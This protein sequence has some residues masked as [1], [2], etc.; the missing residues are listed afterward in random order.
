V[1]AIEVRN[2]ATNEHVGSVPAATDGDVADVAA[3]ARSAQSRWSALSFSERARVISRFHDLVL[4]RCSRIL[5]VIQSETGKARRD[6]FAEVLT[7]AGTARYY[8]AHGARHLHTRKKQGA[9]PFLTRAEVA[10]HPLGVVGL[11]EPWNYPFL[12]PAGDA[13]PALLAGNAVVIK[14]SELTPLSSDLTRELLIESGLDPDLLGVVHGA[15]ATGTQMIRHV[16]YVGFTG[17]TATG[18]KVA[19]AAA[20]RL[21]PFSLELGGKNPMVVL[22]GAPLKAAAKAFLAGTF[23]N[24]GQTC[25]AIERA[26]IESSV[27]D[28]FSRLVVEGASRLKVGWSR[29]WDMDVGSLIHPGHAGKVMA[30]IED[31]VHQGATLL[32]GGRRR[33]DLGPSFV[34][35][36]IFTNVQDTMTI[37]GEETF[38]PVVSLYPV[39]GVEDAVARANDSKY[40]LNASVWSR[41]SSHAREVARTIETGSVAVNSTLMIYNTFDVPMGGIRQSGIGRRHGEHGI[42]RFTEAQS[43]VTSFAAGGGYDALISMMRGEK[44]ANRLLRI[45]RLLK[46]IPWV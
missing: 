31:A 11:I 19:V 22:K 6:A 3:R 24:G 39:D 33:P 18:R 26:Y 34:E 43:I 27:F 40:G 37:A 38:G 46:K 7:V 45:V 35:P 14:P 29:S 36:T 21:I 30:H 28:E 10:Y 16:D 20:E 9:L 44:E 5:D 12:L 42:L 23:S 1:N 25:I 17:S 13:L 41:D 8:L 2:P 32:T 15:G 4:D